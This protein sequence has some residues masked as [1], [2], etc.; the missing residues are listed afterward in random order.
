[1]QPKHDS[2]FEAPENPLTRSPPRVAALE[3]GLAVLDAFLGP[4]TCRSLAEL[5][6]ATGLPKSNVLRS[7]GSLE[8]VGHVVR[9]ATGRYKLGARVMLLGDAY[10]ANFRLED[11]V[12][13]ALRAMAETTGE[14]A[15]FQIR[16]QDNQLTLFRVES[17]Q[18]VRD[19]LSFTTSLPLGA[20]AAGMVLT[21]SHWDEEI[22]RGHARV[23]ATAGLFNAQTASLATAVYGAEGRLMGS[24]TVS[25]PIERMLNADQATR[26]RQM[27][28]AATGLSVA[29]GAS[30]PLARPDPELIRG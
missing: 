17:Q 28:Q 30:L 29:L 8:R 18:P 9:L 7:L 26:A 19:V 12:I 4:A 27:A 22:A 1:M 10:R 21:Q 16:E 24:L 11:H 3:R 25:G 6:R 5:T 20:T 15:A 2:P 13:P 23:Y 14:S